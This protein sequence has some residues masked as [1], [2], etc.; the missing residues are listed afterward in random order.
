MELSQLFFKNK[1]MCINVSIN[2]IKLIKENILNT[3]PICVL[4]YF[5]IH[6]FIYIDVFS[7]IMQCIISRH[8]VIFENSI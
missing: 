8:A 7:E 3:H 1:I 5:D 6:I 4:A 2:F